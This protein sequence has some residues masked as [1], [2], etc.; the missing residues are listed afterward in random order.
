MAITLNW[1][2][3]GQTVSAVKIYRSTGRFDNMSLIANIDGTTTTYQ[4]TSAVANK[5]YYYKVALVIGAEEVP[6]SLQPMVSWSALGPGPQ[7]L[8]SGTVEWGYFGKLTVTEFFSTSTLSALL[9]TP[10]NW[11]INSANPITV[12][13]KYAYFGKILYI[14]DMQL[15]SSSSIT[16]AAI[17]T[18][19]GAGMFYGN[20]TDAKLAPITQAATLQNKRVTKDAYEFKVRA[21][22]ANTYVDPTTTYSVADITKFD[23]NTSELM[24]MASITNYASPPAITAMTVFPRVTSIETPP[25]NVTNVITQHFA[26]AT[27]LRAGYNY[28][29]SQTTINITSGSS[30]AFIPILELVL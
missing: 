18:L 7:T 13:R 8:I 25:A 29:T 16:S 4:D 12:W 9:T 20:D 10:S 24:L 19:Y 21:P 5:L 15:Y 22:T 23:T 6:G 26:N 2:S 17:N 11:S 27:T 28:T 1:N 14:P 3:R 30:I